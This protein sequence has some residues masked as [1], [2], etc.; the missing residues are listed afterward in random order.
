MELRILSQIHG[1]TLTAAP[2]Q[3][4]TVTRTMPY[5]MQ[6]YAGTWMRTG[7]R[8][9]YLF[10]SPSGAWVWDGQRHALDLRVCETDMICVFIVHVSGT[11]VCIEDMLLYQNRSL[12]SRDY[13]ERMEAARKWMHLYAGHKT[14]VSVTADQ[15][16]SRYSEYLIE[17]I[18]HLTRVHR[19][20]TQLWDMLPAGCNGLALHPLLHDHSA[21]CLVYRKNGTS[22]DDHNVSVAS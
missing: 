4:Y 8:R 21:S 20:T 17:N 15:Y 16:G 14:L 7:G 6:A 10:V 19:I 22:R 5:P 13:L 12:I 3:K 18:L 1:E 11:D 9:A 2:T